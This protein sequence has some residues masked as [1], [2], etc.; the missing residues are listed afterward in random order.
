MAPNGKYVTAG[1]ALCAISSFL[2]APRIGHFPAAPRRPAVVRTSLFSVAPNGNGGA[3]F[4]R[5]F[6]CFP[7]KPAYT[8]GKSRLKPTSGQA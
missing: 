2:D 4:S 1:I 5:L 6:V 7:E 3:G 8:V